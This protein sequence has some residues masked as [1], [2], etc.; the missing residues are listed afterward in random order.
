MKSAV[1]EQ[2]E[3][4]SLNQETD[5]RHDPLPPAVPSYERF[6][7]LQS[8]FRAPAGLRQALPGIATVGTVAA[9]GGEPHGS[10]IRPDHPLTQV[11]SANLELL[12]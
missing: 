10:I 4:H 7:E 3:A 5:A 12:R 8:A 11:G 1:A 9:R 6:A 2:S